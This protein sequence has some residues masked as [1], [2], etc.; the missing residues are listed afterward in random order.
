MSKRR[1]TAT[2][3]CQ[4]LEQSRGI[5]T[6]AAARLG[7]S[8]DT[9]HNYAAKFPTVAA[10]LK[11]KRCEIRDVA[12]DRLWDAVEAG[13]PWAIMFALKTFGG[14]EWN[15]ETPKANQPLV[16]ETQSPPNVVFRVIYPDEVGMDLA[17]IPMRSIG[18]QNGH[19][20]Y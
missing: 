7:C 17:D 4:A 1:Y 15:E 13:A 3:V 5:V 19:T 10:T 14:D 18:E 2:E 20:A 8:R 6:N 16:I 12:T 11:S 9:V